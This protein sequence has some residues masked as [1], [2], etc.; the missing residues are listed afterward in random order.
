[1]AASQLP[2]Q[3]AADQDDRDG[4]SQQH[5]AGPACLRASQEHPDDACGNR[6]QA[7]AAKHPWDAR[8]AVGGEGGPIAMADRHLPAA[9]QQAGDAAGQDEATCPSR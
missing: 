5:P 4:R 1:M 7:Q 3:P 6:D 2:R 8:R 9:D